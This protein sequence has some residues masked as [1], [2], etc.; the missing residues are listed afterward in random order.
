MNNKTS[1]GNGLA[2]LERRLWSAADQLWANSP[3]RP[4]EYSTPILGLIFLRF[5]DNSFTKIE[6]ELKG[7]STGRRTTGKTDFQALVV[8]DAPAERQS[9]PLSR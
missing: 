3:L 2:E 1:N 6:A 8:V 4:S 7:K 5:A 9:L